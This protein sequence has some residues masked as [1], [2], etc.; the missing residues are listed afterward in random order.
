[1]CEVRF[2]EKN[3]EQTQKQKST[4]MNPIWRRMKTVA[5][6]VDRTANWCI[7]GCWFTLAHIMG[8]AIPYIGTIL[9]HSFLHSREGCRMV[10]NAFPSSLPWTWGWVG[11]PW[12]GFLKFPNPLSGIILGSVLPPVW[13]Q[14]NSLTRKVFN[15]HASKYVI[16]TGKPLTA[17]SSFL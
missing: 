3:Q 12:T 6:P 1:M 4:M 2:R 11:T 8:Q 5:H 15:N 16:K 13:A 17:H 9:E 7:G 10:Q 14:S